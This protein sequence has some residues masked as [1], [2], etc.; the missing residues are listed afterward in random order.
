VPR[1]VTLRTNAKG[2]PSRW[3]AV[4]LRRTGPGRRERR[5][6]R[7]AGDPARFN[8]VRSCERAPRSP[9]WPS[10]F[11]PQRSLVRDPLAS[12]PDGVTVTSR[13]TP[14]IRRRCSSTSAAFHAACP[15]GDACWRSQPP[16]PPGWA[17]G[18]GA[19]TR[20]GLASSTSIASAR[21]NFAVVRLSRRAPARRADY[22]ERDDPPVAETTDTT[23]SG[24][25]LDAH[26]YRRLAQWLATH[27]CSLLS[28]AFS[29]NARAPFAGTRGRRRVHYAVGW[30]QVEKWS[31]TMSTSST[32]RTRAAGVSSLVRATSSACNAPTSRTSSSS[33]AANHSSNCRSSTSG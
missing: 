29:W 6:Q 17:Y 31:N 21:E 1:S 24:G 7:T 15:I 32:A 22:G 33:S 14:A 4:R 12:T 3:P 20:S 16:Q 19:T 27:R 30:A 10:S 11:T 23:A 26:R 9:N 2:S 5:S 25:T 28:C 13:S 18:Q 8:A